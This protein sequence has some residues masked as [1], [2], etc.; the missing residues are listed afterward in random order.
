[1][2][3]LDAGESFTVTRNGVPM[4]ELPPIRRSQFAGK[5]QVLA[6]F[7][8]APKVDYERFIADLDSLANHDTLPRG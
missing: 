6:A 2:R 4:G 5:Q 8:S 3:A 1:M 7:A